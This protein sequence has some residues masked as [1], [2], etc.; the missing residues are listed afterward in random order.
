MVSAAKLPRCYSCNPEAAFKVGT[1]SDMRL[2]EEICL[3]NF[4]GSESP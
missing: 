2:L 3:E 1:V 4:Q